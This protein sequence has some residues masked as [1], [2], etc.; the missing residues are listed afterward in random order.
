[1]AHKKR[2]RRVEFLHF[3]NEIIAAYPSDT[4]IHVVLDNLNTHKPRNDRWL[5]RHP[6]VRFHSRQRRLPGSTKWKSGSPFWR[7]RA[8]REVD[9]WLRKS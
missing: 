3:M 4:A 7:E 2:R 9:E 1:V 5:K 6:N 8:E